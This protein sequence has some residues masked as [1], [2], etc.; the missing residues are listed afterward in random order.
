MKKRIPVI[1]G[2]WKMFKTRDDALSFIYQV[3]TKVPAKEEVETILF[4]SPIYLR[5]LVKRQEDDLRIGAQNMHFAE[6]GAFTGEVSANMLTNIGTTHILIGHSERRQYFNE[7][8]ESVNKK[9]KTA[10]AHEL[11]PT[12]CVGESLE[13]REAG[14]T[15]AF[16]KNQVV[17]AFDGISETD[18]LKTIIAYEPIWAIGTGRTATPKDANDTIKSIRSN[19][20]ELYGKKVAEEIRILY[21]GSVNPKNIKD[22]LNESDIDGALVG[23]ASLDPQSYLQLVEAAK[24]K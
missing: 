13:T 1:A 22:L 21:G 18:A 5:T 12:V 9:L 14:E 2:N 8:D 11:I 20:V 4:V 16:V 15:N 23:G 19:L 10:H 7:T 6:E 3:N 17:K 24:N